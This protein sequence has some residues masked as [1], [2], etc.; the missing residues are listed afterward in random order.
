[1]LEK[2]DLVLAVLILILLVFQWLTFVWLSMKAA[3]LNELIDR[4]NE[5]EARLDK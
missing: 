1:M 2:S 4:V 5:L 3:E